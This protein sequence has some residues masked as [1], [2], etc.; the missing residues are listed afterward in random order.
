MMPQH[1][2]VWG[3]VFGGVL[4]THMDEACGLE[5]IRCT[6]HKVVTVAIKEVLFKEPVRVADLVSFYSRV[7]KLGRTSITV[8]ANVVVERRG[9]EPHEVASCE[10]VFVTVSDA[11]EKCPVECILPAEELEKLQL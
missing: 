6:N 8:A 7:V 9:E 3:T 2:N 10:M 1:V 4:L 5:A 11:G